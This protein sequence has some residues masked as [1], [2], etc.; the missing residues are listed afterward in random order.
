METVL[1]DLILATLRQGC[2][3]YGFSQKNG[4]HGYTDFEMDLFNPMDIVYNLIY[5]GQL[6]RDLL[7]LDRNFI[8]LF[9]LYKYIL[10]FLE[11]DAY[12]A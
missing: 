12:F 3:K 7:N 8:T 10:A 9:L 5:I 4:L 11:K 2:Q 6:C 1:S